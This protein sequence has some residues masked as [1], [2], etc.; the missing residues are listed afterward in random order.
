M[1]KL[2][3][4]AEQLVVDFLQAHTRSTASEIAEHTGL[5]HRGV[6][7]RVLDSLDEKGVLRHTDDA[8]ERYYL[9]HTRT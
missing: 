3:T 1:K 8:R 6:V 9:V 4:P 7:T 5:T 2:F